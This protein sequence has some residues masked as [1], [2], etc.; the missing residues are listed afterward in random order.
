MNLLEDPW[1]PGRAD[2]GTGE[3]RLLTYRE[4]LCQPGRI[5]QAASLR[6]IH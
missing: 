2:G 1:I 6:N 4:L 5:F 3:F